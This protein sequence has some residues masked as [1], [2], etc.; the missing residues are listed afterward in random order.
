MNFRAASQKKIV[1]RPVEC[2][3]QRCEYTAEELNMLNVT[4]ITCIT[5]S[6]E[7]A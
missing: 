3:T 5:S 4:K 1:T 6:C 2:F 7:I